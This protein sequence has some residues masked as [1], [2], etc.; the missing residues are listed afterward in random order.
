MLSASEQLHKLPDH[1][2][3]VVRL[4]RM[5]LNPD[6]A[7]LPVLRPDE[8]FWYNLRRFAALQGIS[9]LVFYTLRTNGLDGTMPRRLRI[10]WA[11][12]TDNAVAKYNHF[13]SKAPEFEAFFAPAGLVPVHI[14]GL[15]LSTLYPRPELRECGDY[16]FYLFR[17][18][19]PAGSQNILANALDGEAMASAAGMEVEPTSPKHGSWNHG[20]IHVECH[21]YF[22]N[23]HNS[24]ASV[25][26][27]KCLVPYLQPMESRLPDGSMFHAASPEFSNLFVV[28]HALQHSGKGMRLRH[29]A[30][31]AMV[32]RAYGGV[33]PEDSLPVYFRRG[34]ASLNALADLI[35]GDGGE[36]GDLGDD[37]QL[38]ARML[39]AVLNAQKYERTDI[40]SEILH[41]I[42]GRMLKF[43]RR[44]NLEKRIF[45]DMPSFHV[46]LV[47]SIYN[48]CC[49]MYSRS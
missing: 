26:V 45:P 37:P 49:R 23:L 47:K 15:G 25:D 41:D 22:V 7:Q 28:H 20:R 32:R 2:K 8:Q 18:G 3:A 14:K 27:E 30:D 38:T 5:A 21:R 10:K 9:A 36:K 46:H 11:L 4:L 24:T 31:L 6:A 42:P 13:A 33:V 34:M 29:I 16:D 43:T 19:Q 17:K 1:A 39:H 40:K 12:E 35:F 48:K 44:Y